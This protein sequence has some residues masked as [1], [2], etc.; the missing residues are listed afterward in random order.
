MKI[1]WLMLLKYYAQ[2]MFFGCIANLYKVPYFIND[3]NNNTS[4]KIVPWSNPEQQIVSESNPKWLLAH[5]I[6]TVLHVCIT[7]LYVATLQRNNKNKYIRTLFNITHYLFLV[8]IAFN[9]N[10]FI[11]LP[12]YVAV[13][14]NLTACSAL[15][16]LLHY[17]N[18]TKT[19]KMLYWY[20]IVLTLPVLF[21]IINV[22]LNAKTFLN[23][24]SNIHV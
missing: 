3:I 22:I 10:T 9:Y 24:F 16:L 11:N 13:L 23:Y 12:Q 6:M 17:Y 4:Y 7:F 18:K 14:I 15:Q 19:I 21:Q 8:L 5:L 1:K 20:Y 2:L